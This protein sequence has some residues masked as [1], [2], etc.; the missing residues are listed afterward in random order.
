MK[1]DSF[2]GIRREIY[3]LSHAIFSG[4]PKDR[5]YFLGEIDYGAT[6]E[7]C[8]KIMP[9]IHGSDA[10]EFDKIGKPDKTDIHEIKQNRVFEVYCRSFH[11]PKERVIIQDEHPTKRMIIT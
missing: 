8:G 6:I 4:N 11:E 3:G 7:Q 10:H 5:N 1:A 9:C 2:K